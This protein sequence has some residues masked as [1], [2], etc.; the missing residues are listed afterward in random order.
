M[1][2]SLVGKCI[3]S[4]PIVIVVCALGVFGAAVSG[5]AVARIRY[6]HGGEGAIDLEVVRA[7]AV[8]LAKQYL[9]SGP[10]EAR[11]SLVSEVALVEGSQMP[12]YAKAGL[13]YPACSR[14]YLLQK[15]LGNDSL[16]EAALVRARYWYLRFLETGNR[17]DVEAARILSLWGPSQ[18]EAFVIEADGAQ[19]PAYL[20]AIRTRSPPRRSPASKPDSGH[21]EADRETL[22]PATGPD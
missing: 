9:M 17:S 21:R 1:E 8:V 16:A 18:C 22:T 11:D 4:K 10:G 19:G 5:F 15:R 3:R 6:R 2:I 7:H 12:A 14:L 20:S 13:C